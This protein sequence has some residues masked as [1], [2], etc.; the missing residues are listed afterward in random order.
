M[1][2]VDRNFPLQ[3]LVGPSLRGR[4]QSRLDLLTGVHTALADLHGTLLWGALPAG[5]SY[6]IP[7]ELELEPVGH[8]IAACETPDRL[9]AAAGLLEMILQQRAQYL[10][11]ADLHLE[12]VQS[13]YESLLAKH[14]ELEASEARLRVLSRQLEDRVR[15]QVDLI[16][17][18]QRQLYESE[19]LAAV[20]QLA[21]GVAHEINNPIGFV[22]SN[23]VTAKRYVASL[24]ELHDAISKSSSSG[25]RAL[26]DRLDLGFIVE[27]FGVLLDDCVQ[28]ADRI[29]RIV[30]DLKSFASIDGAEYERFD[31]GEKL[32]AVCGMVEAALPPGVSLTC[33][34]DDGSLQVKGHVGHLNQA[35]FNILRNAVQAV[36]DHGK[37]SV[38][39]EREG[40]RVRIEI[41]DD[42]EGMTA[43]VRRRA[44]EPFFSTRDVGAGTGLGL[45]VARDAVRA[46]EGQI[47]IDS[48]PG[49]GCRVRIQL[50]VVT[51]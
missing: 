28:G 6:R 39:A 42:G 36:R 7:V 17:A 5:N 24:A 2:A 41:E 48:A 25:V 40:D 22:R 47:E 49:R 15:E 21:A 34:V 13:D 1:S 9:K 16:E 14:A 51:P 30:S 33:R 50:P 27:D 38:R 20:G 35:L 29:A 32:V 18:R 19:R 3:D 46:H 12:A 23:L 26:S 4:L 10:M 43:E 44:F 11:A 37:V 31:L 45:T 8:L